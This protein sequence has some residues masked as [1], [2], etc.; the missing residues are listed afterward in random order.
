MPAW[1]VT[2]LRLSLSRASMAAWLAALASSAGAR[3]NGRSE[4]VGSMTGGSFAVA[5]EASLLGAAEVRHG[6]PAVLS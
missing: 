4:R 5:R 3:K 2:W 6:P 1:P